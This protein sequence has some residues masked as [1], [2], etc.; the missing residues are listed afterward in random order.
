MN[1]EHYRQPG[2]YPPGC[3]ILWT[4]SERSVPCMNR[5]R[6]ETGW[7]AVRPFL[8]YI[9]LFIT[10]REILFR[11]AETLLIA[12]SAD[13]TAYYDL[14][15]DLAAIAIV[16]IAA[17]CAAVPILKEAKREIMI[18]RTVCMRAWITK[19]RDSAVL[20]GML[21]FGTIC[22]SAFLN[23]LLGGNT[24]AASV[25]LNNAALPLA[26]AVYG[27]LTPFIEEIVYRGLVWH[28]LRRSFS[29]LSAAFLS[30]LLFGAAHGNLRQGIY[31]FVMGM[32]FA[33]GYEVTRRF[34]V[35][36]LLHCTCNLAVLAA[37]TAGW[38]DVLDSPMWILFF[39]AGSLFVFGYW[40]MRLHQTYYKL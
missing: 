31:A 7:Y 21:P 33:L 4:S 29:P 14:W 24:D 25:H 1:E 16:G 6:L 36:F 38:G 19:R 23:L 15:N 17:A 30:S 34:E 20:L 13:M 18:T 5:D 3:L 28:R 22:L 35:P 26:A 10:I 9:V 12:N 40:G 32:V 27:L 2:G 37:S 8:Y 39:A 11:L